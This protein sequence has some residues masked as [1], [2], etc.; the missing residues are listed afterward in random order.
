MSTFGGLNTAYTGLSAAN[1][2]LNVTGQN[3]ANVGTEGY[4]RQRIV[5]SPAGA[6]GPAG[7]FS[8]GAKPGSGVTVDSIARLGDVF[9]ENRVRATASTAGYTFVRAEALTDIELNLGEPGTKGISARLQAFWSSWQDLSNSLDQS[10]PAS[11]LLSE[12]NSLTTQISQGY[13]GLETQ[14]SDHRGR[15]D[16]MTIDLNAAAAQLGELN[17]QIRQTLNAGGSANELMDQRALLAA[18]IADLAGGTAEPG[19]GGMLNV[20]VGGN[21]LVQGEQVYQVAAAGARSLEGAATDPPR[22]EWVGRAVTA[23][24]PTGGQM[25]GTVSVLAP[26]DA[27]GTGGPIAEAAASYNAFALKLG[28]MVNDQHRAG[29]APDGR[30]G[31]DFFSFAAGTPAAKGIGV[32]PRDAS[33]IAAGL[34]GA[35]GYDGTHAGSIALIGTGNDSPDMFWNDFVTR[36]GVASRAAVQSGTLAENFHFGAVTELAS[37]TEVSLDEETVSLVQ[38]QQ[39]YQANARVIS[40]IDEMLDTLINRTGIVGR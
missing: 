37:R 34:P 27:A 9:A 38:Y 36:T 5:T 6:P 3:L 29:A 16:S 14:W 39:A 23:V 15:L 2:G 26:A 25:A 31:L 12:A 7:L 13:A 40:A 30:T 10:A 18:Q 28:T 11:V 8:T 17:G 4:T 1:T 32:L 35:D 22:L 21:A 20:F 19:A 24:N 33:G